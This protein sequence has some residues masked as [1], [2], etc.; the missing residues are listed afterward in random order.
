MLS[1]VQMS[2]ETHNAA[3]AGSLG[4]IMAIGRA[5]ARRRLHLANLT[6]RCLRRSRMVP[7]PRLALLHARLRCDSGIDYRS[8]RHPDL[9]GHC[10]RERRHCAHGPQLLFFL[11]Q[12]L[13]TC[14]P[15][16]RHRRHVLVWDFLDHVQFANDVCVRTR[17]RHPRTSVLPQG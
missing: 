17:W 13:L 3:M 8:T 1:E 7:Y 10:R 4:I 2:E 12:R 9:S 16:H 15:D 14:P 5:S 11:R 6:I